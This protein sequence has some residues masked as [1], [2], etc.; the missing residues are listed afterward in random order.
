MNHS[1]S[2]NQKVNYNIKEFERRLKD[3]IAVYEKFIEVVSDILSYFVFPL[4]VLPF[5]FVRAL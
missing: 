5:I 2:A 4:L 1:Y 3:E